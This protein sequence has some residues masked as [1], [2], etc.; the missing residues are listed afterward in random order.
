[1]A[2]KGKLRVGREERR[3]CRWRR[4]AYRCGRSRVR[5]GAAKELG[6]VVDGDALRKVDLQEGGG[7]GGWERR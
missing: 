6:E 5:A 2:W 3:A 7:N 1:M 4:R